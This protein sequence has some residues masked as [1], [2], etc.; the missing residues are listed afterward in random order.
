M[1]IRLVVPGAY[2]LLLAGCGPA[3]DYA[4]SLMPSGP[5]PVSASTPH[6]GAA[7]TPGAGE[8]LPFHSEM[9][10]QVA[11]ESVPAGSCTREISGLSLLWLSKISGTATSTHLG[12]GP[13]Y[14]ELCMY[15]ILT[16]PGAPPPGN[17]IPMNWYIQTQMWTAANGDRLMATGELAGLAT[18]PDDPNLK[19]IENLRFLDGGT[20]R[21]EFA[22]G[23]GTG[24][25]DPVGLTTVYDGWIRYGRRQK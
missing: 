25:V 15:G 14:A 11:Q 6:T 19:F 2:F 10:W 3:G 23:E 21:F 5:T 12:T 17:G 24:I 7:L 4:S 16:N 13:Y 22:E 8:Q 20:G 9:T 18:P 1:F